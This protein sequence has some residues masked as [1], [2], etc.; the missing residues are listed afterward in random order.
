M[1]IWNI[2]YYIIRLAKQIVEL[3]SKNVTVREHGLKKL[4]ILTHP[5]GKKV[6]VDLFQ[7]CHV[8]PIIYLLW[9]VIIYL[10]D[11]IHVTKQCDGFLLFFK[12]ADIDKCS[13]FERRYC[14]RV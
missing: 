9:I 12:C 4:V 11:D 14:R 8:G 3:L 13:V 6:T 2:H 1:C 5:N 10:L 7:L